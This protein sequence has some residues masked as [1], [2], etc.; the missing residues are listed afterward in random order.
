[1]WTSTQPNPTVG[2]TT[3]SVHTGFQWAGLCKWEGPGAYFLHHHQRFSLWVVPNNVLVPW[4]QCQQRYPGWFSSQSAPPIILRQAEPYR[5]KDRWFWVCGSVQPIWSKK[6]PKLNKT[7]KRKVCVTVGDTIVRASE[8]KEARL[9]TQTFV[10]NQL[11]AGS[12]I[13][14]WQRPQVLASDFL[15][16]SLG[17]CGI[18]ESILTSLFLGVLIC[19][20]GIPV[21][22]S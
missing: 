3:Q 8:L 18:L 10:H 7:S 13:A 15:T 19:I 11:L 6:Y 2:K 16:L 17:S 12:K 22:A 5:D 14:T 1:M 4:A 9:F 21:L 20:I